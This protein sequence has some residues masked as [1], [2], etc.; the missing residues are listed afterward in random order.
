MLKSIPNII[1]KNV[2]LGGDFNLFLNNSLK[3]QGGNSIFRK[4]SLVKFIETKETLDLRDIWRIRRPK[5]KRFTFHQNHIS[6]RIQRRLDSFLIS[7]FLQ[8]T[9]IWTDVFIL[10]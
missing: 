6:G 10:Q 7:H 1:N 2:I 4:K 5:S 9:V 8:E 3:T